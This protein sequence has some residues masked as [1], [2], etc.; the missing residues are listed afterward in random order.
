MYLR[1][2]FSKIL[3]Y[4]YENVLEVF[5]VIELSAGKYFTTIYYIV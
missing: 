4:L 3:K 2:Y 5:E 1:C